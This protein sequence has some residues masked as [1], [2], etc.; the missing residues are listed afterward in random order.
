MSL[1]NELKRRNVIRVAVAYLVIAWLIVQVISVLAPMFSVS[2]SFQR[3]V[4]LLLAVGFLPAM[5]FAWAFEITPEGIKKEKNVARDESIT[6]I[7]AKKL[8]YVTLAAA[9][10]VAGLFGWQQMNPVSNSVNS[11]TPNSVFTAEA[12]IQNSTSVEKSIAVLPFADMSQAGD[13]EWFADG[14]AE[15]ILNALVKVPDLQ[16]TARTSSMQYKGTEKGISIIAQ[17][18]GVAHVLEGSVRS[19]G[20]R[21]RVTAQLIRAS[22]GFHLWS[23]NYDRDVADMI[24]IQEDL[25]TNIARALETTMDP[26][27]LAK[28]ADVGTQSIE[29]YRTY[30]QG[31]SLH[32]AALSEAE[33]FDVFR[34]AYDKFEEARSL[35]PE[36][37]DAHVRAA[38]YWKVELSPSRTD[39]GSSNLKPLEK[40]REYQERIGLAIQTA[41]SEQDRTRSLADRAGVD[42]RLNEA[43]RLFLEYLEFRPNDDQAQFQLAS[44]LRS[45]GDTETLL[46]FLEQW[47]TKGETDLFAASAYINEAYRTVDPSAAADFGLEALKRWPNSTA[48]LYQTHRTLVWAE[49]YEEASRLAAQYETHV[50]GNNPMIIAREAC[51]AGDRAAAEEVLAGLDPQKDLSG[52]W[53]MHNMLG[54]TREEIETLRHLDDSGVLFQLGDFLTYTKFDARPYPEFTK[55]RSERHKPARFPVCPL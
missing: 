48:M 35:D 36:F 23:E 27:A 8:D 7:T 21:I 46:P 38:D 34:A 16:V 49:R 41:K 9:V 33:G 37:A 2:E 53:L 17:E 45:L 52:I 29:A 20:E 19:A 50:P 55:G 42:L 32:A 25:A 51:A 47:K 31:V 40:L 6:N 5:F 18:L 1:F 11:P 54:N 39:T 14:L 12:G 22:D 44:I 4:V 3:G 10:G 43:R 15:E 28:M 13:Q 30:L 26:V 24:G